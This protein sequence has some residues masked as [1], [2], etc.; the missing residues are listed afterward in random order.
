MGCAAHAVTRAAFVFERRY[1]TLAKQ[2]PR[3]QGLKLC[4]RPKSRQCGSIS[5]T[6][7]RTIYSYIIVVVKKGWITQAVMLSEDKLILCPFTKIFY[8]FRGF[9]YTGLLLF[10]PSVK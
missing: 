8:V 5:D 4:I 9:C 7:R 1:A 3:D 10:Y 2:W 6:Q